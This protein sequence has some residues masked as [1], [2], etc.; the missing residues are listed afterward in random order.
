MTGSGTPPGYDR[1]YPPRRTTTAHAGLDQD[2][3]MRL[4]VFTE[5]QQGASYDQ[6]LAVARCAEEEGFDAF[7]RSDHYLK[8]GNVDGPS[9]PDGRLDDPGRAG[10]RDLADPARHPGDV[11][12]VPVPG[13]W[14]SSWPR[15]TP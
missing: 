14:P 2:D 3:R 9:R 6:L 4:R 15:S 5:P 12:H 1:A 10:P 13:P 8:M 11:G 7:F